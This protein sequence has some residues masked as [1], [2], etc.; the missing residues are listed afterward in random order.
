MTGNGQICPTFF[1]PSLLCWLWEPQLPAK[2]KTHMQ[3]FRFFFPFFFFRSTLSCLLL[4]VFCSSLLQVA[5]DSEVRASLWA[6]G[7][8]WAAAGFCGRRRMGAVAGGQICGRCWREKT[9]RSESVGDAAADGEDQEED[10]G[11]CRCVRLEEESLS[12]G[13][14]GVSG[15]LGEGEETNGVPSW[16]RGRRLSSTGKGRLR[17]RGEDWG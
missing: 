17:L 5:D 11:G 9:D 12:V 7:G 3:S 14:G 4:L 8:R 1:F 6:A 2:V 10:S 15:C 13:E 16:G